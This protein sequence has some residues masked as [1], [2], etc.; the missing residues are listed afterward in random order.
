MASYPYMVQ[1]ANNVLAAVIK[2]WQSEPYRWMREHDIQ[3]EIGGRLSQVFML[4]G[5]GSVEGEYG[6]VAPGI[7]SEEKL[8]SWSRVSYEP[9]VPYLYEGKKTPCYP[10]IVIWNDLPP[11]TATPNYKKG[12]PWPILWACEIKY[13]SGDDGKWDVEKLTLLLDQKRIEFGCALR[14]NYILDP[15]GIG[16]KWD[17]SPHGQHLW[18]CDVSFPEIKNDS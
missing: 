18:I 17:P 4:Q 10:D 3:A 11:N 9:Y 8:Q 7:K 13:G 14:I 12:E 6:W 16:V 5:L 15:K 2:Q 1:T